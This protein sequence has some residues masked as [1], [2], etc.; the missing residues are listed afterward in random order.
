[1]RWFL[2][3]AILLW[4][5]LARGEEAVHDVKW[6]PLTQIEREAAAAVTIHPL[7]LPFTPYNTCRP[8]VPYRC[9]VMADRNEYMADDPVGQFLVYFIRTMP[10]AAARLKIEVINEANGKV[11]ATRELAPVEAQKIAFL[12]EMGGLKAGKYRVAAT[13]MGDKDAPEIAGC[14]FT[15][16]AESRKVEPFPRAGVGLMTHAQKHV[17]DAVWPITTGVPLSRHAAN[18]V[19]KFRLLENG[20]PVPAQFSVRAKWYPDREVKW[21]GLDFL[22]RY[23]NGKPREYRLVMGGPAA[24]E[25][26][27]ALKVTETD[28]GFDV[29]TGALRFKVSKTKFAGVEEAVLLKADG[30]PDGKPVVSGAG[31]PFLVDERGIRYSAARDRNVQVTLEDS[32]PLRTTICAKGWY[33]SDDMT[34]RCCQFTTRMTAYAGQAWINVYQETVITYDTDKKKLRMLGFGVKT[35]DA[36]QWAFG[37]DGKA[38]NGDLPTQAKDKNNRPLPL[39]S[40]WLHQD[41]FDHFRLMQGEDQAV[42]TGAKS[43]GWAAVRS[44]TATTGVFVRNIWQLYPKEM[45]L[46]RDGINL[47]FW[48]RHGANVFTEEEET[49]R[50]QIHQLHY[51]HQGKYLDLKFPQKYFDAMRAI[52]PALEQQDINALTANA[53]GLAVSNDFCLYFQ[54]GAA[55]SESLSARAALYQQNPHAIT[56]PVYSGLTE[57]E[58]RFAGSD[59][60]RFPDV[61]RMLTEGYRSFTMSVDILN[62][63]GMW[64]WPNTHN[65]WSP[66]TRTTQWHRW[67]H[68]SHYQNVWEGNFL[69]WRSGNQ[70]LYEWARNNTRNFMNVGT[71]NYDNP[72]DPMAFKL[73]GA[74]FHC[75]GFLPWG[76]PRAGERCG[77]DYVEVGAHFIDADSFILHWLLF[78]DRRGKE[79]AE[80]WATAFQ[81][82]ALPPERSRE[83]VTAL[84]DMLSYYT[85]TWDPQAILYIRD[86]AND[87]N[88]RPWKEVPA[89]PVHPTFHTR[90]MMR[91]WELTRDPLLKERLLEAFK[92]EQN[93]SSAT[94]G[95]CQ[96][97]AMAWRWTED[98]SYLTA[99]LS[100]LSTLWEAAY[101]NPEDPLSCIGARGN[102]FPSPS[103]GQ[104]GPYFLQALIDAGITTIPPNNYR[105]TPVT[106]AVKFAKDKPT[107]TITPMDKYT[108][109]GRKEGWLLA[110]GAEPAVTIE[111]TGIVFRHDP[112]CPGVMPAY[113]RIEDADGKLLTETC[114]LYGSKRPTATVT[115]DARKDKA[116]WR[117]YTSGCDPTFKWTGAAEELYIGPTPD[118]VKAAVEGKKVTLSGEPHDGT[119]TARAFSVARAVGQPSCDCGCH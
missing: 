118:A 72:A 94:Y 99:N 14:A 87:M 63:Y 44:P 105:G 102:F 37:G 100:A 16:S 66:I 50:Q 91:Y 106:Q 101:E 111:F 107:G 59:P 10:S 11:A 73:K 52:G 77:D 70:M 20:K 115:L 21:M 24:A 25:P 5:G 86:L 93:A 116:P 113:L 112:A 28:A 57:V 46:S 89:F 81:R 47:M 29:D 12:L 8:K 119:G 71:V 110:K 79:L 104:I 39:Q 3:T 108:Y 95:Y 51:A 69:Y 30:T 19:S 60:K 18:D 75:K 74:M 13:L 114:I 65:N 48:P 67:W 92:P 32:G 68:N 80:A 23:D 36:A 54:S 26:A 41:R 90:W 88:S 38:F 53:L 98:R 76:S 42:A 83:C 7:P 1:M 55:T 64:I 82:V 33:V 2:L 40:V 109:Y 22:A 27:G 43:D 103:F 61:E 9:E 78:G 15:K 6:G 97:R 4:P 58:G 117:I 45:E 84:G 85:T 56:D 17:A 34:E 49:G 31:G 62:D 96:V 35:A